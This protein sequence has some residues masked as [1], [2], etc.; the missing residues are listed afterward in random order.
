MEKEIIIAEHAGFCYGVKRAVDI[1][2][3]QQLT[4]G[5]T[6]Y[7]LGP[8]IHNNDM[9]KYLVEQNIVPLEETEIDRLSSGDSIV[10]RS[11]GV[12]PEMISR[13]EQTGARVVDATCPYVYA[14]QK[15]VRKYRDL[16]YQ[17]IIVGD[18]RHPEVI[19]INGWCD[20]SA[21]ITKDGS[22]I[23]EYP[24]KVCVVSQTTERLSNYEKV[25]ALVSR[26]CKE[27]I[28]FNTICKATTDRQNS[29]DEVSKIVD[30]MIVVGGRNSSNSKKLYEI[31]NRNCKNTI[32]I[33]NCDELDD[34]IFK[35][36]NI[37]KVGITA[38]AST[39][40]FVIQQVVAKIKS[41]LLRS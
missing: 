34:S 41:N 37:N 30:I 8:L 14:I 19:G 11:H 2:V 6:T 18:S 39:P 31:C 35:N 38:G 1:T 20:N 9:I 16:G 23:T 5:L 4:E 32:F 36:N 24:N 13:L 27:V 25:V 40:N 15:K 21:I 22:D 33:E 17:I 28:T 3:N 26:H 10:I 29:A 7:T 12:T